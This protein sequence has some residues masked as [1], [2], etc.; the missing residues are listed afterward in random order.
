[1][2]LVWRST[3]FG[4]TPTRI[5][6]PG[7]EKAS[8]R[9]FAYNENILSLISLFGEFRNPFY[10][11]A[12][13]AY[14]VRPPLI[15]PDDLHRLVWPE[16]VV[17][18]EITD[19]NFRQLNEVVGDVLE[20]RKVGITWLNCSL[21]G[22][23]NSLRGMEQTMTDIFDRP[24]WL[25]QAMTFLTAA[26]ER[27]LDQAQRNGWLGLNNGSDHIGSS[28]G[29]TSELPARDY[30]GQV[31]PI[32]QWGHATVQS[33]PDWSPPMQEEFVFQYQRRLLDR[34]GLNAYGCCEPL[35]ARNIGY[36]KAMPRLRRVIVSPWSDLDAVADALKG[37][38]ILA[39]KPNP[40]QIAP[41][42]NL[43]RS[44]R[45]LVEVLNT[46]RD[47]PA[48]IILKDIHTVAGQPARLDRFTQMAAELVGCPPV[49]NPDKSALS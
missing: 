37:H 41:S 38:C 6:V 49:G 2:P 15:D 25:H 34:F 29:F 39:W 43:D 13:Q 24:Q 11:R 45:A 22:E 21:I 17:D 46:I 23:L 33:A 12:H 30:T 28:L 9:P 18:E 47:Q 36:V 5:T 44:R 40:A 20:V 19:R 26:V 16:L 4:L 10:R 35:N 7:E 48:E 8:G 3:G 42:F 31:R 27:Q 1:V 32:D 14:K